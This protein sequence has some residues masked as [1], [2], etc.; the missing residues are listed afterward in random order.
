[1]NKLLIA[2]FISLVSASQVNA[3]D[4]AITIIVDT[5]I[6]HY[7]GEQDEEGYKER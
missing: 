5:G 6:S 2:L 3:E 4:Q 1:M 7:P